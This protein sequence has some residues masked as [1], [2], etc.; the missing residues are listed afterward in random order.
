M[1]LLLF[2]SKNGICV[3]AGESINST[4]TT[5]KNELYYE[6]SNVKAF[7]IDFRFLSDVGD[8]EYDFA[9]GKCATNASDT[10]AIHDKGNLTWEAKEAVDN[11]LKVVDKKVNT[12]VWSLQI[13]GPSCSISLLDIFIRNCRSTKRQDYF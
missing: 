5:N 12:K 8:E 1:F 11:L 7:K 2:P 10:K 6:S 9:V 3:E 4:S 13:S